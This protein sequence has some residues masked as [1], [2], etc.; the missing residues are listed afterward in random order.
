MTDIVS[1]DSAIDLDHRPAYNIDWEITFFCNLD[2]SYCDSHDNSTKHPRADR[3][4][5]GID[6]AFKYADLVMSVKKPYERSVSLNILGGET[7]IHPDIVEILE[8]MNNLYKTNYKDRWTLTTNITTNG[9]IGRNVLAK[10]LP[11]ITN[12][13]VSYHT[14]S[15]DKQKAMALDT[16]Y[17]LHDSGKRYDVR[18]MMH[19]DDVRFKECQDLATQFD[20]D[21]IKYSLKPIGATV[22]VAKRWD[23]EQPGVHTYDTPQTTYLL[24]Y[25]KKP[26]SD[27]IKI[28][29]RFVVASAGYPCCSEKNMCVNGDRKNTTKLIGRT[30]FR[31][32]YCSV[33]WSFLFIKQNTE[34]IFH[35]KSCQATTFG[36]VGPI[37][38]ISDATTILNDFQNQI[39]SK[40]VPV[41]RCPKA[42]C[43]CGICAPKA[44]S[45]DDFNQ[46]IKIHIDNSVL[47]Y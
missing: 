19:K 39:E 6:F 31:E 32:W 4:K 47:S 9:V 36:T 46:L 21:G 41:I 29:D 25:W 10:C 38:T 18:L 14:E 35:N 40:S 8:Y 2:C 23:E 45:K 20:Q 3:C 44:Q 34:E 27:L 22:N 28:D 26:K 17:M 24:N 12:W 42:I 30:E 7:L 16:I 37:G 43:G 11:I 1:I 13:T 5:H 15:N 33:N